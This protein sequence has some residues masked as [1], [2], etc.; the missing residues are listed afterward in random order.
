MLLRIRLF[1]PHSNIP[2]VGTYPM[3]YGLAAW[4]A[5]YLS[6][7]A[8]TDAKRPLRPG[9]L[10]GIVARSSRPKVA[11]QRQSKPS[12]RNTSAV[13]NGEATIASAYCFSPVV[14]YSSAAAQ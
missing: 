6:A 10:F 7:P 12:L 1:E 14:M 11:V 3:E 9:R 8:T 13:F 5:R 2:L 4:A